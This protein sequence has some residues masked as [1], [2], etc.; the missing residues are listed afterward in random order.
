MLLQWRSHRQEGGS[1][2][3]RCVRMPAWQSKEHMVLAFLCAP[4]SGPC[5]EGVRD[6]ACLLEAHPGF[7]ERSWRG[8]R[9]SRPGGAIVRSFVI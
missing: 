9:M 8:P 6:C 3:S 2:G 1:H 5:P 4:K 7:P